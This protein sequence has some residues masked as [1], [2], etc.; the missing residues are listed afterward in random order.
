MFHNQG[1]IGPGRGCFGRYLLQVLLVVLI[2]AQVLP[3]A[4]CLTHFVKSS[5]RQ[6]GK[7]EYAAR[8]NTAIDSPIFFNANIVLFDFHVSILK[9]I[10]MPLECILT[11]I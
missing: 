1:K 8:K 5:I 9:I 4:L 6:T 10:C 7:S 3:F 11:I 2:M